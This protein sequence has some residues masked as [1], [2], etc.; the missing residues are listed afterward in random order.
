MGV[1]D[2]LVNQAYQLGGAG[3]AGFTS[4]IDAVQSGD[5]NRAAQEALNSR[6]NQQ[7]P[8]RSNYLADVFRGQLGTGTNYPNTAPMNKPVSTYDTVPEYDYGTP[9]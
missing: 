4:M 2:A 7:T 8:T 1:Q 3:Q 6:W 9:N 5:W